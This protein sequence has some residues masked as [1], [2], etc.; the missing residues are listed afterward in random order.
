MLGA[1][2][3]SEIPFDAMVRELA[4]KR[5]L[6]RHPLFQVLFSM[7]PPFT[8]FPEGWDVT[9]M[10][11]HSGATGFDLFVEFSEHPDGFGRAFRIQYGTF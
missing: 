2:T 9:D 6:S 1:L 3:H 8:D 7:R 10:E 11:V 4:P 5:D